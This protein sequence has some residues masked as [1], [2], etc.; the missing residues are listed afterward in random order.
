MK[1]MVTFLI[2]AALGYAGICTLV[3]LLQDQMLF[4]PHASDPSATTRLKNWQR[5]IQTPDG[6]LAGGVIPA[7]DPEN[8][9]LFF[10]FGGNAED[11]SVTALDISDNAAANFVLMN[12]RGYGASE[13]APSE[14]ALFA[15]ALFVYDTLTDSTLHNGKVVAFG[16]SLGSGV[17]V[18]LSAHRPID[19]LVLVTPY[20]SIQNVARRRFSW[21]PVSRLLRHP[22]DSLALAPKLDIPALFLV[23]QF[24]EVIPLPHARNLNDA[25][26][27]SAEW[28]LIEDTTHNSIGEESDYWLSIR[29]FLNNLKIPGN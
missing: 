16:R 7:Q 17:A 26:G 14:S 10:Y 15:D 6:S 28:V 4:F 19:A 2:I 20:D 22:F 21:L 23:A 13:G 1:S 18:Y 11:V 24:D 12:Y 5:S 29:R 25:W 8:A 3:F 9:P 27:G